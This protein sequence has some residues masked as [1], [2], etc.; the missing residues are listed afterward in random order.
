MSGATKVWYTGLLEGSISNWLDFMKA[1][2]KHFTT[3]KEGEG[4]PLGYEAY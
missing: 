2:L 1:F 4:P 3:S